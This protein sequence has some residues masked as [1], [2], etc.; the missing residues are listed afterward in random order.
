MHV[1]VSEDDLTLD[2]MLIRMLDM[3]LNVCVLH[4]FHKSGISFQTL[5]DVL[6]LILR[7]KAHTC[8]RILPIKRVSVLELSVLLHCCTWI[9]AGFL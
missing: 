9:S 5:D 4:A 3:N 2:F 8:S 6:S 7:M 1:G